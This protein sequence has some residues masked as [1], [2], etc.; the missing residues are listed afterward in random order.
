M[1]G[2]R[3]VP[4]VVRAWILLVC[5]AIA[6]VGG[7]FVYMGAQERNTALAAMG[8]P[9]VAGTITESRVATTTSRKRRNSSH[10]L[11]YAYSV[12]G[13]E[14]EGNRRSFLVALDSADS[15]AA[16]FAPAQQ[17]VVHY[18]PMDPSEACLET[19]PPGWEAWLPVAVGFLSMVFSIGIACLAWA[20]SGLMIHPERD[21]APLLRFLFGAKRMDR[22]LAAVRRARMPQHPDGAT[23]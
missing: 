5:L 8:W 9:T 20:I 17:V 14:H 12:D 21:P 10:V 19:P 1:R 16:R 6:A 11:R 2:S 22:A 4:H 13:V 15:Q 23:P 18:N 3:W 7:F